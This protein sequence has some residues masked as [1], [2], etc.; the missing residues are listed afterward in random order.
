VKGLRSRFRVLDVILV[1]VAIF[2]A[3][4]SFGVPSKA[5]VISWAH[6]RLGKR[7]LLIPENTLVNFLC[8]GLVLLELDE[9]GEKIPI[10][11]T[12]VSISRGR[13]VRTSTGFTG[14]CG[15]VTGH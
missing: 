12:V 7:R 3:A 4:T 15:G 11:N 2:V 10:G 5:H 14:N 8:L 6:L 13:P 9:H 1:K